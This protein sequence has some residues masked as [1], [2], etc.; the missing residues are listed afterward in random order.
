MYFLSENC[1]FACL[2]M[3]LIV[4][5]KI[6]V[7]TKFGNLPPTSSCKMSAMKRLVST[8]SVEWQ[9]HNDN[10]GSIGHSISYFSHLLTFHIKRI[11]SIRGKG[12]TK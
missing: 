10:L 6:G 11:L 7:V 4:S 9:Q 1:V 8:K 12:D 2:N 3:P 5:I